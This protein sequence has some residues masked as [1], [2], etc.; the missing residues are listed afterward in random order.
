MKLPPIH[1]TEN[2]LE[3]ETFVKTLK[4]HQGRF[5]FLTDTKVS[6]LYSKP[7]LHFMDHHE[8]PCTLITFPMGEQFK[9]RQTKEI[10]EDQLYDKKFGRDTLLIVMGGGVVTDLGGFIAAT[11]LRGIPYVSIPT[12]LLAMVDASIGGKTGVNL[13]GGKNIIGAYYVP[14]ALFIDYQ[15][16]ATLPDNQILYGS[17]EILKKALISDRHFYEFFE[18][19]LEKWKQRDQDFLKKLITHSIKLKKKIVEKDV[20]ERGERHTLN[21]GHTIAHGIE[22]LEDYQIPHGEA[23]A[24]GMVVESFISQKLGYLKEEDFEAIYTLIKA[25]GFSLK[26]SSH[27]TSFAMQ[28]V[29]A[30][31]KKSFNQKPRFVILNGIGKTVPFKGTFCTTVDDSLLEEVFGWMMAEFKR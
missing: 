27:V 11:Y 10:V 13:K 21:F 17:A 5:A 18:E 19:H 4:K 16:L 31:D 6:S 2:L 7:F 30:R 12:S 29:I 20:K 26:L 25:M 15:M 1:L 8:L 14:Q 22:V 28:E 3:D 23:V 24:L 9:T